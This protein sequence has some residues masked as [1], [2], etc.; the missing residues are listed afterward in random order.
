MIAN[1]CLDYFSDEYINIP[2]FFYDVPIIKCKN[3]FLGANI[4]LLLLLFYFNYMH[5]IIIDTFNR[6]KAI[7]FTLGNP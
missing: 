5:Q 7:S 6:Y 4:L 3:K 1:T 2:F